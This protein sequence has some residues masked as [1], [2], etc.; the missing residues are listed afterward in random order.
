MGHFLVNTEDEEVTST[1]ANVRVND[2]T[3]RMNQQQVMLFV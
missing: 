2:E 1:H 3:S